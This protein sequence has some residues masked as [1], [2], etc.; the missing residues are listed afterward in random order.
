M[1]WL[2]LNAKAVTERVSQRGSVACVSELSRCNNETESLRLLQGNLSGNFEWQARI[3]LGG[4]TWRTLKQNPTISTWKQEC[5]T[6]AQAYH[7]TQAF[8]WKHSPQGVAG[9][10]VLTAVFVKIYITQC[11]TFKLSRRFG[12]IYKLLLYGNIILHF[13]I[14]LPFLRSR[15][16]CSCSRTFQHFMELEGSLPCSQEPS[17]GPYLSQINPV[18]ITLS[19]LSKI[20]FNIVHPATPWSSQWSLSFWLSHQY[21]ILIPR[22]PFVLHTLPPSSSLTFFYC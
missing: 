7:T 13:S 15:Q 18:H 17:T 16:L 10:E 21:P 12:S 14:L 2:A 11:R 8:M 19:Y 20:H 1:E 22:P 3:S 6:V 9:T 4:G 5:C